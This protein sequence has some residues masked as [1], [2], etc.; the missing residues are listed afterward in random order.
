MP[1]LVTLDST[2]SI[3]TERQYIDDFGVHNG[4]PDNPHLFKL[5]AGSFSNLEGE[6]L[7][8]HPETAILKHNEEAVVWVHNDNGYLTEVAFKPDTEERPYLLGRLVNAERQNALT[9]RETRRR[10]NDPTGALIHEVGQEL[11]DIPEDEFC[12]YPIPEEL[13]T[14]PIEAKR[15]MSNTQTLPPDTSNIA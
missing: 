14:S 6:A 9:A 13:R 5:A 4:L 7:Y 3:M 12:L 11:L 1:S 15:D 10:K 2:S 8:Y